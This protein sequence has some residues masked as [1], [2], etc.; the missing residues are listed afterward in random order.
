MSISQ[1]QALAMILGAF[2]HAK[3]AGY[4]PMQAIVVD[5]GGNVL[6]DCTVIDAPVIVPF[7]SPLSDIAAL[8]S[9]GLVNVQVLPPKHSIPAAIASGAYPY[10][11]CAYTTASIASN[12]ANAFIPTPTG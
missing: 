4:A 5:V 7:I 2:D 3:T 9:V 8:V 6:A 1:A 12:C 10:S 11:V